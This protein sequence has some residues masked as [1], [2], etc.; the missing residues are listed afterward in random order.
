MIKTKLIVSSEMTTEDLE[1]KTNEALKKLN[2]EGFV[3]LDIKIDVMNCWCCLI[4][5]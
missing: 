4:Y 1:I 3:F 2:E 5:K